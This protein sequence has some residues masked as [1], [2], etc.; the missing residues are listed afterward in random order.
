[1]GPETPRIRR[2]CARAWAQTPFSVRSARGFGVHDDARVTRP[3]WYV[4]MRGEQRAARRG[5]GR[6]TRRATPVSPVRARRGVASFR[7][8]IPGANGQGLPFPIASRAS[9]DTVRELYS[10]PSSACAHGAEATRRDAR[11]SRRCCRRQVCGVWAAQQCRPCSQP[12][13]H[14]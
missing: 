11:L 6:R 8:S 10:W 12:H 7:L 1:M 13:S 2:A 5:Q 9:E 14:S 4:R 3:L